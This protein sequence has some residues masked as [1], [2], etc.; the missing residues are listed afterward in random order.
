MIIEIKLFRWKKINNH[1]DNNNDS[2]NSYQELLLN[3]ELFPNKSSGWPKFS[4]YV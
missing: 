2:D 1:S 3:E 4:N